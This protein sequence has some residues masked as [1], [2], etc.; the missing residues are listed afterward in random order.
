[1]NELSDTQRGIIFVIFALLIIIGWYHFFPPPAPIPPQQANKPAAAKAQPTTVRHQRREFR[2]L[3][4]LLRRP[5]APAAVQ[6]V[7]ERSVVVESLLN[8]VQI[9]NRGGV[10]RSWQLKKYLTDQKPP[11]PQ[12]VVNADSSQELGW[13]L[14]LVMTEPNLEKA[15][16]SGLYQLDSTSDQ[17]PAPAAVTMKWSDGH[18]SVT[19]TL[20]FSQDYQTSLEV[21][22]TLD[23]RAVPF[24]VAWR[25]EFGDSSVYQAPQLVTAYYK[26][27]GKLNVLQYRKMGAQG[28][29]TKPPRSGRTSRTSPASRISSSRLRFSRRAPTLRSGTGRSGITTPRTT[30]RRPIRKRRSR[31]ARSRRE[32]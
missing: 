9:S 12:D 10:I 1:M 11:H 5:V 14:S 15:A 32:R 22:V 16:N 4:R 30:R 29:Q 2:R 8:R 24:A 19:K 6:D 20:K 25:G 31:W 13:P 7:A 18:L 28:D 17:V 26:Q 21:S 27:A 23:G 3:P